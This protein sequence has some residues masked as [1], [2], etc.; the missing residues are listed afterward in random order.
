MAKVVIPLVVHH[1]VDFRRL[2]G[3][4]GMP[5]SHTAFMMA[6]TTG[7]AKCEGTGSPLFALSLAVTLLTMADA[8]GVRRSVGKQAV[9][10]NEIVERLHKHEPISENKL[11]ELVG[12]TPFE[13]VVGALLGL[14]LGLVL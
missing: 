11:I 3:N 6:L 12:H 5:S 9:V 7:I 4:G 13:V 10:L 1:K 14:A 2:V 8:S